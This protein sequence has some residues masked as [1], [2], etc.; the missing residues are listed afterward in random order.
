VQEGNLEFYRSSAA[1]SASAGTMAVS[2][3][4]YY[5][6][7]YLVS[8]GSTG[9]SFG[10]GIQDASLPLSVVNGYAYYFL[11]GQFLTFGAGSAYGSILVAGDILGVAYDLDAGTL[12]FYKNGVS[13]GVATSSLTSASYIPLFVDGGGNNVSLYSSTQ[14]LN[15]G[16]DSSFAGN[17]TRQGNTDANGIGDFYYAPPAG[18][19]LALCTDNLPEPAIVQ[20]ETQ[21]NVVTYTG[22]SADRNIDLGFEADFVWIKARNSANANRLY[23]RVRGNGQV[24]FSDLSNAEF[25]GVNDGIHFDYANGFN[26]DVGANVTGYNET[27]SSYVAWCWKA[28]GTAVS[29]TDGSITS[30]VSANVDAGFSIVSYTGTGAASATVGHGLGQTPAMI[31]QKA[32]TDGVYNWNSWHKNLDTNSYISLNTTA[33]QDN[34]VNVWPTAGITSS[35]FTTASS[36]VKYNNL[37][38]VTHIAYCFAEVEGF[39]K[40]GSYV[41]NGSTDGPFVYT[42]FKPALVLYKRAVGGTGNW[43]LADNEREGYN[44]DNPALYPNLNLEESIGTSIDLLANGFKILNSASDHNASGSTYIYMAFAEH[45]FKEALAR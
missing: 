24:L 45:P 25:N 9:A 21:F 34:S 43:I 31:I 8:R 6:E 41:G 26:I 1:S 38:G 44:G 5:Y 42:S 7:I 40:F 14:V 37:S 22:N 4:K 32:A 36:A 11:N 20:P 33:A 28:G 35:V 17:K 30:Q 3:G 18:G 23:D 10:V 2:S 29:N 19:Y 39:S 15:Y 13:L 16:A 27:G 12:T